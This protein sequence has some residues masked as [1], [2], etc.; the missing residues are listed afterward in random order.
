[1]HSLTHIKY[2]Q[3]FPAAY[4]SRVVKLG[5]F[6]STFALLAIALGVA[7]CSGINAQQTINPLMFFLPGLGQ[8]QSKPA[9]KQQQQPAATATETASLTHTGDKMVSVQLN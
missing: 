1:M 2:C 8:N 9:D 5:W 7:G 6:K 4:T 3:P